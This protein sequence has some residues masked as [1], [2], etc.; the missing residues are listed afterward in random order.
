LTENL[1]LKDY[2]KQ[3]AVFLLSIALLLVIGRGG[4]QKKPIKIVDAIKYGELS[5]S[6]L[7]LNTPFCILKT[8]TNKKDIN[9]VQYLDEKEIVTIYKPEISLQPACAAIKKNVVILILESFGD[10]NVGRGQTPFL[11]SLIT[12]SYYF[13]NGF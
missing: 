10:E 9:K 6:A 8:I 5:N 7:V 13:K 3:S 4:F 11:D 12:K 1:S 2:L